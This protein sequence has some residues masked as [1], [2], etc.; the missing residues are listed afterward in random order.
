MDFAAGEQ[1]LGGLDGVAAIRQLPALLRRLPVQLAT[2]MSAIHRVDP[3]P[4][5]A[6][7][8]A[9]APDAALTVDEAWT[10][11]HAGAAALPDLLA[12]LD[13]LRETQPPPDRTVLCHGDL[14]PFNLLIDSDGSITVLD[15]TAAAIAPPAYD[16]ALTWLLLR[17]PPLQ[18]PRALRPAI[19][20][21][22]AVLAQRFLRAYRSCNPDADLAALRWYTAL[23]SARVL[24]DLGVWQHSGDPRASTHPWRLVAPG[25][26]RALKRATGMNVASR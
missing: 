1:L 16:V 15:W 2:T 3:A 22:S 25:A 14:H 11:L 4:I 26:A 19:N 10:H 20:A 6:R 13:Q 23:H 21:G 18:A 24:L 7:V 12:A 17:H 5:A 8:R 9:A